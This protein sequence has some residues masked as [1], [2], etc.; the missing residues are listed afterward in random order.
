MSCI[1]ASNLL[2]YPIGYLSSSEGSIRRL[3][4][5]GQGK[6]VYNLQHMSLIHDMEVT[7]GG[8]RIVAVGETIIRPERDAIPESA[9][10]RK[11]LTLG[12]LI[13]TYISMECTTWRPATLKCEC[14]MSIA[15]S[16]LTLDYRISPLCRRVRTIERSQRTD[17]ATQY[18][19]VSYE[20]VS[21]MGVSNLHR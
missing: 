19:L 10:L 16:S 2:I 17:H 5:R 14:V 7:A 13:S 11:P 21:S 18:F 6:Q 15:L 4:M 8:D 9:I 1:L 12:S 3:D 20:D